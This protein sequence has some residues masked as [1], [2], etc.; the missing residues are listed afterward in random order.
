MYK[1]HRV[2][3]DGFWK[4]YTLT[5]NFNENINIFIGPNGTGKTTLINILQA[6]LSVDLPLLLSLDY[7]EIRIKLSDCIFPGIRM[8]NPRQSGWLF[9]VKADSEAN[10]KGQITSLDAEG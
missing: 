9:H 7:K 8:S 2:E 6:V 5:T 1:L 3:I 10:K 4:N